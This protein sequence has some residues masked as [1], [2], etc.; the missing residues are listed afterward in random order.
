MFKFTKKNKVEKVVIKEGEHERERRVSVTLK[1]RMKQESKRNTILPGEKSNSPQSD[2]QQNIKL[3]SDVGNFASEADIG[4]NFNDLSSSSGKISPQKQQIEDLVK[5]SAMES[6]KTEKNNEKNEKKKDSKNSI[7]KAFLKHIRNNKGAETAPVEKFVYNED[8]VTGVLDFVVGSYE[9]K[10]G[11]LDRQNSQDEEPKKIVSVER[12]MSITKGGRY[13]AR[14]R[15]SSILS[16]SESSPKT[17]YRNSIDF[18]N[19]S[20]IDEKS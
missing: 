20:N 15:R 12:Q 3:T 6:E 1:G 19:Y 18:I 7:T 11:A 13:V 17:S 2:S 9:E 8:T 16:E 14:R 10:Y 4:I 5:H